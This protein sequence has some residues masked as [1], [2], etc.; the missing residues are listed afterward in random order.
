[1]E[2]I[3]SELFANVLHAL[4]LIQALMLFNDSSS[5]RSYGFILEAIAE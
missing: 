4:S 5:L 2:N 1:M 3:N